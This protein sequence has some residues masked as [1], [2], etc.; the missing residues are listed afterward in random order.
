M[1]KVSSINSNYN[2]HFF[3]LND[4]KCIIKNVFNNPSPEDPFDEEILTYKIDDVNIYLAHYIT[5]DTKSFILRRFGRMT[6]NVICL[7][8][9]NN[10]HFLNMINS[11]I[12]KIVDYYHDDISTFDKYFIDVQ[13]V[14]YY[15]NEI[16]SIKGFFNFHNTNILK[17]YDVI[18]SK[19]D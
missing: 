2:P 3:L 16:K 4:K 6:Q 18:N 7:K 12:N 10:E 5:L 9:D 11:N 14:K 17:N 1:V 19:K 8:L 15:E 13:D